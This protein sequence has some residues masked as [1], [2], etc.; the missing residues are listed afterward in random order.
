[1]QRYDFNGFPVVQEELFLGFVGREKLRL[2]LGSPYLTLTCLLM[3]TVPIEQLLNDR[4]PPELARECT[5]SR[6]YAASE[7][8]FVDLSSLMEVSV[9]ELRTEVPLELVVNMIHKMVRA[10]PSPLFP[11]PLNETYDSLQNLRQI[12]FTQRGKL[13]GLITK[14]DIVDLLTVHLP[15]RAALADFVEGRRG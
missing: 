2:A 3:L 11:W 13:M 4:S 8:N 9:L 15:H 10:Y 12:L 14:S 7:P 5:F 6:T 1:M